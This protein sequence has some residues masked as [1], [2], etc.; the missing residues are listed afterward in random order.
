M[1]LTVQ[2]IIRGKTIELLEDP[3]LQSGQAVVVE[4]RTPEETSRTWG[5]GIRASA[6]AFAD[7]EAADEILAEIE[8][9]RKHGPERPP[10]ET[11][12]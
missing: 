9:Y 10:L 6:G 2:G 4:V 11:V 8:A 5:D 7:V 1:S 3:G 12:E